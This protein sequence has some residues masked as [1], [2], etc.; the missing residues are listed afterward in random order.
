[1]NTLIIY[2]STGYVISQASGSVR[3]PVGVPFMWVEVPQ[4]KYVQSIDVSGEEHTPVF[5]DLPKSETQLLR[6]ENLE[7]KLALA[8]LA[9]IITEV[10]PNG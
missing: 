6:E 7:I 8:E 2:D 3:E 10:V 4:S 9:E 1:M 5:V